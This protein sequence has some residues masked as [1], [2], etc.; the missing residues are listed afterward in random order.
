MKNGA[1][2]K[3]QGQKDL[4]DQDS[5]KSK[6]RKLS[7]IIV[8]SGQIHETDCLNYYEAGFGSTLNISCWNI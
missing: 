1:V 6:R 2:A 4:E 3:L 5:E 8:I 7:L